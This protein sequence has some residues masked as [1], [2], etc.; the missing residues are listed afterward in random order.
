MYRSGFDE[1]CVDF[2]QRFRLLLFAG[3]VVASWCGNI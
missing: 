2:V 3:I 1:R